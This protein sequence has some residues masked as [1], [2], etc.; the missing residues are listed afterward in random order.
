MLD[1]SRLE[2]L[3]LARRPFWQ[4]TFGHLLGANYRWFP[5][6]EIVFENEQLIPD[7]PVIFAMNHTD[8]F[9]YFPFQYT[10]W[11]RFDRFTATW[12][13]GKY[14]ENVLMARFMESMLQLPTVSRGYLITRDFVSVMGRTPTDQ[15]YTLLRT[16]VD[17]RALGDERSLL[18]QP[19]VPEMLLRRARNPFGVGFPLDE[20]VEAAGEGAREPDYA[21]YICALYSAMMA[22]FVELNESAIEI[23]LD[24]LI[25]PQ[26]TR[27]KRLLPAHVGISQVALHLKIPIV[28]VGCSGSDG[29]YPGGSPVGKRGRIVYRLGEPIPFEELA[30]FH[31]ARRFT[32]FSATA[33]RDF[34]R[35]FRGLAD[36]LTDRMNGLLDPAYQRVERAGEDTTG[37]T[38]RFL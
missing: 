3:T 35:Q 9:N 24:L 13:K 37:G 14:Y 29:V 31:V 22:R 26:G 28:P 8:R 1:L 2:R 27:S 18:T 38:D 16:A 15:E 17:A 32:P 11:Q 12:V 34:A 20:V 5:G 36:L 7:E 4:R 23:G 33:E 19:D 30:P 25:F 21:D 6:V 10:I